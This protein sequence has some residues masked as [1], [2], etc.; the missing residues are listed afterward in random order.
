MR[1]VHSSASEADQ[2]R[3]NPLWRRI[4]RMKPLLAAGK[5]ESEN[6]AIV[7]PPTARLDV[8]DFAAVAADVARRERIL[9]AGADAQGRRKGQS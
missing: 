6:F 3:I 9:Y 2:T 7:E 4:T 5:S 1:F 8:N